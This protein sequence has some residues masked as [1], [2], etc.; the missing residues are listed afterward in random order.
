MVKK[1]GAVVYVPTSNHFPE[2]VIFRARTYFKWMLPICLML[3][4]T[5]TARAESVKFSLGV[6]SWLA[7]WETT[8]R[9]SS[10]RSRVG[11]MYGPVAILRYQNFF[12]GATYLTGTFQFPVDAV[13]DTETDRT[14]TDVIT[15]YYF[16]PYFGIT[17][18][19]KFIDFTFKF[20]T[21]QGVADLNAEARGP[22]A[23]V[24]GSYPL[25]RS[26]FLFYGNATY[27]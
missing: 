25:G 15:G 9:G 2:V 3:L 11:A 1:Q 6:K 26:A 10:F 4:L 8:D 16:N 12:V 27:A 13:T 20:P 19:Y 21:S 5:G 24:L 23:G 7:E 18:G 22:F 17:G 14:D